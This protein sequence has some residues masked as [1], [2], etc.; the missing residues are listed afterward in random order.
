MKDVCHADMVDE[1]VQKVRHARDRRA[2][3]RSKRSFLRRAKG[4]GVH[5]AK[6]FRASSVVPLF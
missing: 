5:L 1:A 6:T 2:R 4:I 3:T